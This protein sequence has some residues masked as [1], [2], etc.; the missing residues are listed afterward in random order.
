MKLKIV[1]LVL[2]LWFV[3]A[4]APRGAAADGIDGTAAQ[5]GD[6]QT[7]LPAAELAQF[8]QQ[9]T[10][11]TP[12]PQ[13]F[14]VYAILPVDRT[15]YLGLGTA[16]P[17]EYDGSLLASWDGATL[18]ALYQPS[19]QGFIE[20][21]RRG[22]KL[23]FPGADPMDDWSS[24]N[25]Y[26]HDLATSRTEK[27]RTLPNVLHDWGLTWDANGRLCVAVGRH[28]GDNMTWA[29]GIFTSDDAGL[30][31]KLD[32]SGQ[33]GGY[34][35]YDVMGS[36][37]GLAAVAADDYTV[38][39]P[40]VIKPTGGE[41]RR[42]GTQVVCRTRLALEPITGRVLAVGAGRTHL[43]EAFSGR[44]VQLTG[45]TAADWAYNVLAHDGRN[46][47]VLADDGRV[48]VTSNLRTWSTVVQL[49]APLLSIGYWPARNALVVAGRGPTANLWL[50]DLKGAH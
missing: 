15:V 10:G 42:P 41:W 30:T 23:W 28:L 4:A 5:P 18:R 48:M 11:Y 33:L 40:L 3:I 34:R 32:A 25:I 43:V 35:T 50:I 44:R 7:L 46:L 21:D 47:Y 20:M 49:A 39:C 24:G 19:E 2:V 14:G 16:R 45:F 27:L 37:L 22:S 12:D 1:R 17:A 9:A 38:D 29:G 13:Y 31:W 36:R 26:V 6:V 8:F